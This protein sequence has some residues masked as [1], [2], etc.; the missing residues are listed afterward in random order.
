MANKSIIRKAGFGGGAVLIL[1]V[2]LC[3]GGAGWGAVWSAP[4]QSAAQTGARTLPRAADGKPDLQGIWQAESG[5]GLDLEGRLTKNGAAGRSVVEGGTIPY[6][7]EA[8]AKRQENLA[9]RQ[10]ADPMAS[11]FM[12]GVPRIMYLD[13]P[14]QIFQTAEHVAITF[15]WS[16]VFRLIYLK[17]KPG[18]SGFDFWMGHS[19]GRWDGD[20]FVVDVTAQND[21]TWFDA[22]GNHHSDSGH[23]V[24]RYTLVDADTIR[25]E[26]TV[27][28]P[29]TFTRSWKISI[30]LHRRKDMT[31]L[32]EFQCQAEAEEASGLFER[33]P[34]TWYTPKG[35]PAPGGGGR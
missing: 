2:V 12:P 27:E 21:R 26:V 14:F 3:L 16:Q 1:A 34:R 30:P 4:A 8:L 11:C 33:D 28:D 5:V 22:A 35:A 9:A 13:Y 20:T 17:G 32:L 7:P 6:R 18:P 10:T 23:M 24:E 25:Y 19:M 29:K 31:R 15:E